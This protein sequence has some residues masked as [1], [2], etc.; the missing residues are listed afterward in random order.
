[1]L[2]FLLVRVLPG[3][4][5]DALLTNVHDPRAAQEL[6]HQFGLDQPLPIQYAHWLGNVLHGDLG[7][8]LWTHQAVVNRLL[9][10]VPVTVEL[11]VL[12]MILSVLFGFALG[13]TAAVY[14]DRALDYVLRSVSILGLSIPYFWLATL[15]LVLPGIWWGYAAPLNYKQL[16]QDPAQNLQQMA[17]PALAL[18]L[19]LSAITARLVRSVVLEVRREDFARTAAAKGLSGLMVMRGHVLPNTLLPVITLLGTQLGLLLGGTVIIEYI[20]TLP[21]L[22]ASVLDSVGLRDYPQFQADVLVFA[23][24]LMLVNLVVDLAYSWLD[25]RIRYQ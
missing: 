2:I 15:L 4:V 19:T 9:V 14:Q 10:T 12:A 7:T 22:G 1:M 20:F 24:M 11:S 25:P 13:A 8:S 3:D 21:G 5:A 17:F 16:W 6:R 23:I 18:G